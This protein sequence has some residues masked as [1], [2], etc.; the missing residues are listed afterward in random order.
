M[1]SERERQ[2]ILSESL[3]VEKCET[4]KNDIS[5]SSAPLIT[6]IS[7]AF[8]L[9]KLNILKGLWILLYKQYGWNGSYF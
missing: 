5:K 8:Q 4:G 9:S 6:L 7:W 1:N 3:T 2:S